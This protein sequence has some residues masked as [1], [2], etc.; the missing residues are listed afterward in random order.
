MIRLKYKVLGSSHDGR[1][2]LAI[3]AVTGC[4]FIRVN[5]LS[6]V[7][8]SDQGLIEGDAARLLRARE[9]LAPDVRIL[10]DV[11]VKHGVTLSSDDLAISMEETFYRNGAD[12]VIISGATTGREISDH[13]LEVAY[14]AAR[15]MGIPLYLGSGVNSKN[16]FKVKAAGIIVGSDFR[17]K[18]RAGAPLDGNRLRQF[19]RAHR[20]R[21]SK[22]KG[23]GRENGVGRQAA[24][25]L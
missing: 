13:D 11:H 17:Q 24:K 20:R 19:V 14:K 3:A 12:A 4:Q 7:V 2:A 9:T 25:A 22:A 10:A 1:S 15:K 6:G 21:G 18:G 5:V 8:A 16:I 23:R